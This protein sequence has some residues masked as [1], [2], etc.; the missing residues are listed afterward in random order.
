M[1]RVIF[2]FAG[3]ITGLV[4]LLSFK[5]QP[6]TTAAATPPAAVSGASSGT[7]SGTEAGTVT[8]DAADTRF[9][10][11]QVRITVENGKLTSVTAVEYPTENPRDQEINSYAI[12]QLNDEAA[13]AGSADIDTVS[14]ATYTSD[15]YVKSLQSALDK[16]GIA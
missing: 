13:Q 14:G 1:K 9:G 16:A 15:G 6:S 11:V 2:A 7:Q 8:G 10:P 12:P 5:T 4:L 3:T